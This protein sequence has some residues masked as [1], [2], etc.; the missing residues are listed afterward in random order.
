MGRRSS[1]RR[2]LQLAE[3]PR[4]HGDAFRDRAHI[5]HHLPHGGG[6][7]RRRRRL[8]FNL[9][10]KAFDI[11]NNKENDLALS[12]ISL[13]IPCSRPQTRSPAP[14]SAISPIDVMPILL[15]RSFS[16]EIIASS[17]A[18]T[19]LQCSEVARLHI[20]DTLPRRGRYRAGQAKPRL[21]QVRQG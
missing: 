13:P 10:A 4:R 20:I 6:G 7:L 8:A 9:K 21:R 18:A 16:P 5:R 19:E 3:A 2:L 17:C 14:I 11:V 15:A 1:R 12:A